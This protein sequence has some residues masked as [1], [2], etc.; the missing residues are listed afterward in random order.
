MNNVTVEV[1]ESPFTRRRSNHECLAGRT[2]EELV[3]EA[4]PDA[5]LRS[6]AQVFLG[7]HGGGGAGGCFYQ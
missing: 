6:H 5:F 1:A 3:L 4:Q 7:G 2:V